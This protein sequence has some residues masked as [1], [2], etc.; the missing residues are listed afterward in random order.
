MDAQ[1]VGGN[2]IAVAMLVALWPLAAATLFNL[3]PSNKAAIWTMLGG[4]L[5]LPAG[6]GVKLPFVPALDKNTV[7]TVCALVGLLACGKARRSG[8]GLVDALVLAALFSPTVTSLQNGDTAVIGGMILPGVSLYDGVSAF[9]SQGSLLLAFVVGRW[10]VRSEQQVENLVKAMVVAGL[11]YSLLALLEVRLSPQLSNW[12]YG[13][14]P[15]GFNNEMRYGGFR[16]VV[17]QKNGLTLAFFMMTTVLCAVAL[18]RTKER[19]LSLPAGPSAAFLTFV[20]LVSKSA[21]ATVYAACV[22]P[23][24]AFLK[25]ATI[26]KISVVLVSIALLYPSLRLWDVFPDQAVVELAGAFSEQRA[27]S[28]A[29]RFEQESSLLDRASERMVF[30]W[31][32]Y[33][34]SRI[35]DQWGNDISVTDGAWIQYLGQFG[36]FGFLAVFGLSAVVVFQANRSLRLL[37]SSKVRIYAA[38]ITLIVALAAVEQLPNSSIS[39]WSI[40][41]VGYLM[42]VVDLASRKQVRVASRSL[43]VAE[44]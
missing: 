24:I 15:G 38:T 34:R 5:L 27:R 20:L 17:F 9:L 29:F 21:G 28:L 37:E 36:L 19:A 33:G 11:L 8:F 13:Y 25:P 4:F 32:R 22:A 7:P 12:V 39:A 16:P 26:G 6:F 14:F 44:A 42:G 31:G 3:L 40:F 2:W 35:Y 23:C 30:G 41:L 43:R 10:A 1:Q 18:W